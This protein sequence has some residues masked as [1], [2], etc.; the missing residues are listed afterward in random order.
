ML[1]ASLAACAETPA[2]LQAATIADLEYSVPVG[3]ESRDV[4]IEPGARRVEWRPSENPRDESIAIVVTPRLPFLAGHGIDAAT[5][6]VGPML[7]TLPA[8]RFSEPTQFTSRA[9]MRAL[10]VRG[11][12]AHPGSPERR[13]RSHAIVEH[14]DGLV[15]IIYTARS[16]DPSREAFQAVLDSL[17]VTP[18]GGTP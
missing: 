3:W 7:Q 8:A 14:G 12:F 15:H 1:S 2:E 5:S 10:A 9:G 17:H 18:S 11:T 16:E 4:A 6:L 13:T